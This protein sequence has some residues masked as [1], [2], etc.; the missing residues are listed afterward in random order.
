MLSPLVGAAHLDRRP[1]GMLT[2][3]FRQA[4]MGKW[5]R[6][7]ITKPYPRSARIIGDAERAETSRRRNE[8]HDEIRL[9]LQQGTAFCQAAG[10]DLALRRGY[11]AAQR[12]VGFSA[13]PGRRASRRSRAASTVLPRVAV[14]P[15]RMKWEEGYGEWQ[16][17][18]RLSQTR[19]FL[20]GPFRR[21]HSSFELAPEGTGTRLTFT[22]E[23]DCVGVLGWLTK[24]SGK[25]GREGDKRL[26]AIEKLVAEAAMPDHILGASRATRRSSRR[27]A[28]ALTD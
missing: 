21:S 13:L 28:G 22:A 24:A 27:R 1:N 14:G 8:L 20:N 10:G 19:N 2:I 18:R 7:E 6:G 25:I 5:R 23:V 11:R 12:D 17:N 26:A 16:E 3:L 9:S 15:L 4:N